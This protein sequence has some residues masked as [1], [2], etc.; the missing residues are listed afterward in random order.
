MLRWRTVEEFDVGDWDQTHS[1]HVSSFPDQLDP[2]DRSVSVMHVQ[3]RPSYP[4]F[5]SPFASAYP[6][7][8]VLASAELRLLGDYRLDYR[9]VVAGPDR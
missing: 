1:C 4:P 6:D 9:R 2:L 5:P 8:Q 7:G 3:G